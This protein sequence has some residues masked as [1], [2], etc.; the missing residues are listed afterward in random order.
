MEE[1]MTHRNFY[2]EI[3]VPYIQFGVDITFQ[4]HTVPLPKITFPSSCD[5]SLQLSAGSLN[6]YFI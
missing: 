6:I 3:T 2:Q 5:I 4:T 1:C